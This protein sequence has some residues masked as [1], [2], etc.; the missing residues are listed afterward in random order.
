MID[1]RFCYSLRHNVCEAFQ[2]MMSTIGGI[3]LDR[4]ADP[5]EVVS[6]VIPWY[7]RL[8]LTGPERPILLGCM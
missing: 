7:N 1:T 2:Q 6:L 5:D 8:L 4:M 3:P